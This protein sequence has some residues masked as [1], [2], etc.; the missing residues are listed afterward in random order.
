MNKLEILTK[1]FEARQEEILM[2]QINIDNYTLSIEHIDALSQ[3]D[4][5][6]LAEFRHQLVLRLQGELLEQKKA[7]V[8]YSVIEKQL[9]ELKE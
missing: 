3:E 2:Y 5:Q 9:E 1:A 4:Q 6:E 7:K 8:I